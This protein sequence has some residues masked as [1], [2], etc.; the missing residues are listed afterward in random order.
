M[1]VTLLVLSS[2]DSY[3]GEV[4]ESEVV[5]LKER[6]RQFRTPTIAGAAVLLAVMTTHFFLTLYFCICVKRCYN[7]L[8]AKAALGHLNSVRNEFSAHIPIL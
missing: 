8:L 6:M 3:P 4:L 2:S 5:Q 1:I 7:Y